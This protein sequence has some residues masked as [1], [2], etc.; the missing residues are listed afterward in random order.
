[1]RISTVLQVMKATRATKRSLEKCRNVL[2]GQFLRSPFNNIF[3]QRSPPCSPT[4][5]WNEEEEL[6]KD[7]EERLFQICISIIVFIIV[8]ENEMK[9]NVYS[10]AADLAKTRRTSRE[11]DTNVL[12]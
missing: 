8:Y 9:I 11:K 4:P 5:D 12:R 2:I 6:K 10:A 1:M 7:I 3:F